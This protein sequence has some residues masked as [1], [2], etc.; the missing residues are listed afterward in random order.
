MGSHAK[1]FPA[2]LVV[3]FTQDMNM[4]FVVCEE[5]SKRDD[6]NL[7]EGIQT[8]LSWK[9]F[10]QSEAGGFGQSFCQFFC[11]RFLCQPNQIPLG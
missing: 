10:V 8:S 3:G 4:G 5:M 11:W 9:F 7:G 2:P 1:A 6:N